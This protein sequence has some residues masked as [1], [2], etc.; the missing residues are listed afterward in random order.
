MPFTYRTIDYCQFLDVVDHGRAF[1]RFRDRAGDSQGW[2]TLRPPRCV[3]LLGITRKLWVL[4]SGHVVTGV[5]CR[6]SKPRICTSNRRMQVTQVYTPAA[7]TGMK[8]TQ[9][10]ILAM[11]VGSPT[12]RSLPIPCGYG[13]TLTSR[14]EIE[15]AVYPGGV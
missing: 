4:V 10:Q 11:T 14:D 13:L 12:S 9:K 6:S 15:V 7:F 1:L 2:K 5:S 8:T 3:G